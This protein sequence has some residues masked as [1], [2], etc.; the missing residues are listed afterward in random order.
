[1][2]KTTLRKFVKYLLVFVDIIEKDEISSNK[3][4][5]IRKNGNKTIKISAKSKY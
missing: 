5:S 4:R 3:Y 2:L 1:M